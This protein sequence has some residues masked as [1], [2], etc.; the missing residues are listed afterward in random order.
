MGYSIHRGQSVFWLAAG[1]MF[2]CAP[3]R[4]QTVSLQLD[5]SVVAPRALVGIG[6]NGGGS[7]YNFVGAILVDDP[8]FEGPADGNGFAHNGWPWYASGDLSASVDTGQPYSGAQCQKLIVNSAPASINQGRADLPQAPLV[9]IARPGHG[10]RIKVRMRSSV[11]DARVQLGLLDDGWS[12]RLGPELTVGTSWQVVESTYQPSEQFLLRGVS[13]RFLDAGTFWLDDLVAWDENDIDPDTGLSATFVSRLEDLAPATL[14]LGGLGVNGIPLEQYLRHPWDLDYGPPGLQP[15]MDLNTFLRLCK[16][17]GAQP[18]ITVPP[19]FSDDTHWQTG[20][21]TYEVLDSVFVDHGNLVDYV[22]GDAGTTYG[23][24]RGADGFG[25]WDTQFGRIYF[26]LGN[27][28]WGTPD[29]HWD[30][31]INGDESLEQ[32]MQNFVAYNQ[33]RMDEMKSRPGWRDNMK[34]GFCGRSPDVWIGGWPGSYDGTVVPAIGSVT[35]FSTIDLYYGSGSIQDGDAAIYAGLFAAAERQRRQ[36]IDMKSAFNQ[37]AGGREIATAVYEGNA[38]WGGYESDLQNPSALYF[39][40]VSLGAAVSLVDNYASANSAGVENIN[41][42]HYGGNVWGATGPYP[43]VLRKPDFFAL[44]LLTRHVKGDMVTCTVTGAGSWDDALTGEQAVPYV[45]CYPY[46][47]GDAYSILLVNRNLNEPADIQIVQRLVPLEAVWL[48]A[49][50]INANNESAENVS[51][52]TDALSGTA[53]DQV[54]LQLPPHSAVV[55]KANKESIVQPDGGADAG[56]DEIKDGGSEDATTWPDGG[57]VNHDDITYAD[58]SGADRGGKMSG[59]CGC[60]RDADASGISW[61][62]PFMLLVFLRR[63]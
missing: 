25:R 37:A 39:K 62:A 57:E 47:D 13:I 63:R 34:L 23:T 21:L 35:D 29:D 58:Q 54:D 11:A 20:D 41:H 53:Q 2:L 7:F 48:S 6:V 31:D 5:D 40:E 32:Q 22:G 19:A 36:I 9:M 56:P 17:V 61:L 4:A 27:E 42:F 46:L 15:D 16:R 52:H 44:Q 60:G 26:E 50:D 28:L 38:S 59:S 43:Q 45:A 12:G 3:S 33:C 55:L 24:R 18:F 30:M 1:L 8:G 14:R 10:Y 51:L 49:D